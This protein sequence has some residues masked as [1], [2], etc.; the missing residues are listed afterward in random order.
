MK[1][2]SLAVAVAATL[3]AGVA[4]AYTVG[5]PA[6]GLLVPH[7]VQNGDAYNTVVGLINHAPTTAT[8]YWTFFDVNSKH[9]TDGQFSMSSKDYQSFSWAAEAGSGLENIDG[10]LVF[11]VGDAAAVVDAAGRISGN[12]F[13]IDTANADVAYVPTFPILSTD[14]TTGINL[15]TMDAGSVNTLTAGATAGQTMSLRYFIDGAPGGNDT[16]ILVWSA[17]DVNG[18][19]TVNIY[20]D[21]QNRKSVNFTLPNAELNVFNPETISGRPSSFVDGFIDWT[22]PA[23]GVVSYSVVSSSAFSA[24]QTLLNAHN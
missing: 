4:N 24:T 21:K 11:T 7:A 19:Y 18:T 6:S 14:Y 9:V 22:L 8:V 17:P 2:L 20:D 1:K 13:Q 23:D 15:T 3:T 16:A 10:Y 5:R 12:A